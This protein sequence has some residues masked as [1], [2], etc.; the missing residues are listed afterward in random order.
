MDH[1]DLLLHLDDDIDVDLL[2]DEID[3]I[4]NE[5]ESDDQSSFSQPSFRRGQEFNHDSMKSIHE[6]L[7]I[8]EMLEKLDNYSSKSSKVDPLD[9]VHQKEVQQSTQTDKS[10]RTSLKDKRNLYQDSKL[11][12]IL[13][14]ELKLI[15]L[16]IAPPSNYSGSSPSCLAVSPSFI[17]I[18]IRSGEVIVFNHSGNELKRFS[19]KKNFGQVTCMDVTD[20]EVVAATGYHFGQVAIWDLRTGKCIRA[21]N[22]LHSTPVL[23]LKFWNG[24]FCNLISGDLFGRVMMIEYGKNLLSTSIHHWELFYDYIGSVVSFERLIP[25]ETWPHPTDSASLIAL[26]G[27]SKI[28]VYNFA[29]KIETICVIEKPERTAEGNYPCIS[30][31]RAYCPG[32]SEPIDHILAVAWGESITL[33]RFKFALNEGV[34]VAGHLNSDNEIKSIFWLNFE[35]L[36]VLGKSREIRIMTSKEM[37]LAPKNNPMDYKKAI[38]DET[39]ANR[40]IASQSYFKKD[41]KEYFTFYNTFKCV[42]RNVMVLGNKDF[43]KGRLLN[44]KE[45]MEELLKKNEWLEVLALGIDLYQGKGKKLYGLPKNKLELKLILEENV[46]KFV[47]SSLLAWVHKISSAIEFCIGIDSLDLLFNELFDTFIDL[48]G[49]ENMKIFMNTLE[50]FVL[51]QEIKR[52]PTAI[53]GKMIGYYLNSKMP[54]VL[55]KIILNLDPGCIDP[56]H[57][58]AA[59]EEHNLLTAYI[60]ISTNSNSINFVL[61]MDKMYLSAL[62]N[63]GP[64]EKYMFYK[65]LWYYRLCIQGCTFPSGKI[66]ED[67]YSYVISKTTTWVI[68]KA[69][70]EYF[71]AQDSVTFLN[72]LHLLFSTQ[73]ALQVLCDSSPS[74]T[75]IIEIL[76]FQR[77]ISSYLFYQITQFILKI[78]AIPQVI[79]DKGTYMRIIRYTLGDHKFTSSSHIYASNIDEYITAFLYRNDVNPG[80]NELSIEEKGSL[81]LGAIKR[82]GKLETEDINELYKLS[83][84][85]PFTEVQVYLLELKKE[86]STC[87]RYF[88]KCQSEIVRRKVFDWLNDVFETIDE[89]DR[90]KLKKEVMDS[91]AE[92]VDIDSDATAKIVNDWY[93]GEHLEIIHKL[94]NAPKLQ[95]KYLGELAKDTLDEDLVFKYVVL[96]CEN[97]KDSVLKFLSDRDDYNIEDC[98]S[99][100]LKHNVVEAAAYLHEKLGNVQDALDILL[101][102]AQENTKTLAFKL[103]NRELIPKDLLECIHEDIR[104]CIK[105]CIRNLSRLDSTECEEHWF[106]VLKN[107]LSFYKDFEDIF[108]FNPSL[109]PTIHSLIKEILEH[110]MGCV[111]FN[112]IITFITKNFGRIPFRHFKDNIFQV[113]TKHSYQKNIVR[114]AITLLANDVK[115]MTKNLYNFRIKGMSRQEFC[116]GCFG[117]LVSDRVFHEKFIIFVCGHGFHARCNRASDCGACLEVKKRKGEM[118]F[119]NNVRRK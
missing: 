86:Y 45:C 64:I 10:L 34:Q 76:I 69:H 65:L 35:I 31:K 15:S 26:A 102:R 108:S 47:K 118:V 14:E 29:D 82:C 104:S 89:D 21:C 70:F 19:A 97:S 106:Q 79:L 13:F 33:Y 12:V 55:E 48:G 46:K 53:L 2:A 36:C 112:K 114:Q 90:E 103:K 109:E 100:C 107:I 17:L 93:E 57:V 7:T 1:K 8:R 27:T 22:T 99:Q 63:K 101:N 54:G 50:P 4:L 61:P 66:P 16:K 49:P 43:Q 25:D 59:C 52:I 38:L 77:E 105:L 81:L 42:D 72:T 30:W 83:E 11:P 5:Q 80:F 20:D 71:L 18:G 56:T 60:F 98:L 24:S 110:M 85:S 39:Y 88:I 96:L 74:Y 62:N 28:L 94:D 3:D 111:D 23:A 75:E 87:V 6:D 67:L 58:L 37:N 68:N 113:L 9:L 117:K 119:V 95:M 116:A 73:N 84:L 32:D 115:D 40:D 44:W 51:G 91:L 78:S 92:F 41:G